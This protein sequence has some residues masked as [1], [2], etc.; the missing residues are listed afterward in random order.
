MYLLLS[1]SDLNV[2]NRSVYWMPDCEEDACLWFALS[3]GLSWEQY[4]PNPLS[5]NDFELELAKRR[6]L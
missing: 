4:F 2:V 3:P 1:F 5:C 6:I